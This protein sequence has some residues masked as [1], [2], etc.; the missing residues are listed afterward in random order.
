MLGRSFIGAL[1][2]FALSSRASAAEP[3]PREHVDFF[4]ARIRPVL[5][6]HCYECHNSGDKAEGSLV[7]DHREGLLRGGD[8]GPAM[9]LGDVDKSLL[10]QA[11][12]HQ[13]SNLRMPQG[14][15]KLKAEVLADFAR[16]IRLGAPDPRDRAPTKDELAAAT[17]WDVTRER[18]KQWWSFQPL[19]VTPLPDPQGAFTHPVD[20]RLAAQWREQKIEPAELADRHTL[21]RRV[22]FALTGLPPS[23]QEI[24]QFV[25][26]SHG[27]AYELLVD[28]LL[29]S[30]RFGER[31]ARHWMDWYRYAETHGSEGDPA[32]PHAWRYR[33]YLIRALNADVPYDQLIREHVAGDLLPQPRLNEPQQINESAL[34]IG[35]YRMVQHGFVPTDALDEFARFTDNQIDTLSKAV[36]GL[37]LS[38]A[39]CHHHKF[40]PLS[41]PD[42]YAWYGI[43]SSCRPALLTVDLPAQRE[44]H[45]QALA[46]LKDRIRDK[47]AAEWDRA[48]DTLSE[49]LDE[50]EPSVDRKEVSS[51][52]HPLHAWFNVPTTND[53]LRAQAWAKLQQQWQEQHSKHTAQRATPASP[54]WDLAT[55]QPNGW[56]GHGFHDSTRP[57]RAGEFHI[58][59][60]G[61]QVIANIYPAGVYTHLLS[62]KH[63]SVL[64]SPKFTIDRDEIFVR[65]AG[66]GGARVRYVVQNYVRAI[67]TY[68]AFT[69]N[70]ETMQWHRWDAKYW[71]G[72]QAHIEIATSQDLPTDIKESNDRSWFG[73]A[74]VVGRNTGEPTPI[75]LG[76]PLVSVL[77]GEQLTAPQSRAELVQR[78]Q[79][80]LRACVS[81]WRAGSMTDTQAEFLGYFVRQGLLPNTLDRLREVAPLVEQ[82]RQLEDKIPT[83]T[84]A[85][86]I[87]EADAS[88]QPLFIRGNHRQR[89][90]TVPRRFLE[91][92]DATPYQT[93][94]SGRL[95]LARS[96]SDPRNPLVSRVIVNRLWHHLFGVGLV[97]TTDNFG[98][99]GD[100]PTHGEL[101][102]DLAARF[103]STAQTDSTQLKP[104]SIKS[105]IRHLVTSRAYQLSSHA[106]PSAQEH[107]PDNRLLSHARVRRLEA[108]PLRDALLSMSGQLDLTMAGPSVAGNQRRRSVYVQ[109]RRN[110]LDPLLSVFDAPE[111]HMT[112]GRRESTNVPAQSLALLN[113][114]WVIELAKQWGERI[115]GPGVDPAKFTEQEVTSRLRTMFVEALG[116]EPRRDEVLRCLAFLQGNSEPLAQ[117]QRNLAELQQRQQTLSETLNTLV[118]PVRQ[119]LL[120]KQQNKADT[121]SAT[122]NNRPQPIAE[123][124]FSRSLNDTLGTLH[125]QSKGATRIEQGALIL[126]GGAYVVT[127]P[128]TRSLREKTLEVVVQCAQLTQRGGGVMTV[129]TIGGGVFDSIVLGE[130]QPRQW[131]AGSNFFARSKP[132]GGRDENEADRRP[133]HLLYAYHSDGTIAAFRDGQPYG[134]AYRSAGLVTFE[135]NQSHIVFGLRHSP[136]GGNKHFSGRLIAGR[137]YDRALSAEQAAVAAQSLGTA[138][139]EAQ[140][141]AALN[142]EQQ[143]EYRRLTAE[144]AKLNAELQRLESANTSFDPRRAWHDLAQSLFNLKEF[145]Y[146]R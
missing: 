133:V 60:S 23:P 83:P 105:L 86:G 135:P 93:K 17:S 141:L 74:E 31:W 26:D 68:P 37:T 111:P 75:E 110:S 122:I 55:D 121:P 112:Q 107:D 8:R 48:L 78:Y 16:W 76:A 98:R 33:D 51:W 85:P 6:E 116:R 59:P 5:V 100:E 77:A 20:R 136:E 49:T 36:L 115:I 56:D 129:E 80:S 27:D 117:Q 38:C 7:L 67:L 120:A 50:A 126:E 12:R 10:L 81:A 9:V 106:S 13:S 95:E 88:D 142:A 40:D 124:D 69:P 84:R 90:E 130:K 114:P 127:P 118:D 2:L 102:D 28:R 97:P 108:E 63:N 140:L 39:R 29:A 4:E 54:H 96:L 101:L 65:V 57:T 62:S 137:L 113:D 25:N 79:H 46:R 132:F 42:Y 45:K 43:M 47:T 119:R 41:Q 19:N 92:F 35:H 138:I 52:Q 134:V 30:P 82:Y 146:V 91:A 44:L 104:W 58:L 21:I 87:V 73:I 32:V 109:V 144:L 61:E 71:R 53:K 143:S 15:P 131:F 70:N 89:G 34:G 14:G 11:M 128:L 64:T 99:L 145:S 125:A 22:T 72:E 24:E 103:V 139:S 18:R 1:L 123:W 94:Q 66:R 3:L